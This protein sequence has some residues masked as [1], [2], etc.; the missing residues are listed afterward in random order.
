MLNTT[1]VTSMLNATGLEDET[2]DSEDSAE[3]ESEDE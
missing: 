1:N 3:D 2:E